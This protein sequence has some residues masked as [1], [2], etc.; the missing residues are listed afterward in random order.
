[1]A[2]NIRPTLEEAKARIEA[3]RQELISGAPLD[4]VKDTHTLKEILI[5]GYGYKMNRH[6]IQVSLAELLDDLLLAIDAA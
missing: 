1:M 4:A 5:S 6:H 2:E 3:F